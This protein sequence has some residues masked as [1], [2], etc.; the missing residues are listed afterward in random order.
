MGVVLCVTGYQENNVLYFAP[1]DRPIRLPSDS[2]SI[3][4]HVSDC[5][6]RQLNTHQVQAVKQSLRRRFTLI[7]GPPGE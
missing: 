4:D 7:Q 6:L 2:L 1:L 3:A 5:G